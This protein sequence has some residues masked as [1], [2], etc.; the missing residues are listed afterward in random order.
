MNNELELENSSEFLNLI[1]IRKL[2]EGG[3]GFVYLVKYQSKD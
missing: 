1:Y 2:G 3:F